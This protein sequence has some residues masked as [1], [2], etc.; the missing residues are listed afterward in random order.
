MNKDDR[1]RTMLVLV[2][3]PRRDGNSATLARA[4]AEGAESAGHEVRLRFADAHIGGFLRDCRSCRRPDGSCSIEDGYRDLFLNDFLDADG[5]VLCTPIYWYGL[6]AQTKAF[7]DRS[8]CYYAASYPDAPR[9]MSR[10][11]G[12]HLGLVLAAEES[13]PGAALGI[14]HAVQEFVRYTHGR[15]AGVVHGVGNRRGEVVRDPRDPVGQAERLG[16][17]LFT[18]GYSDY[19]LETE[20]STRVWPAGDA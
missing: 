4:V 18:R 17:E 11:A 5:L 10:I 15:F 1:K 19:R 14:V 12:K 7:F 20:R 8:F 3:S 6:S 16:R 2:G 9:V 13:Y